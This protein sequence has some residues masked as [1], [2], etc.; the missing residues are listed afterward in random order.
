MLFCT[1]GESRSISIF[2]CGQW[3]EHL[4]SVL[5]TLQTQLEM[6]FQRVGSD[7]EDLDLDFPNASKLF[8]SYRA[9]A[10]RE[11]WLADLAQPVQAAA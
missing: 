4:V 6:G 9:R 10:V 5:V 2:S 7:L 3:L 11:G 1:L 8:N